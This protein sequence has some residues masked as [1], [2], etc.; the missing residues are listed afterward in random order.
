MEFS[1]NNLVYMKIPPI[2][3]V[4]RFGFRGKLSPGYMGLHLLAYRV[5]PI[6][7]RIQFL[8]NLAGVNN[9]FKKSTPRQNMGDRG[10]IV[11]P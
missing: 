5:R 8:E 9:V 11:Q 7:Y 10:V 2:R 6:A 3:G 1:I 4:M